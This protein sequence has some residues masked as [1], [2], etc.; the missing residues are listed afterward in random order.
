MILQS[1]YFIMH[2]Y[3]H[4]QTEIRQL[5]MEGERSEEE[6]EKKKREVVME[7]RSR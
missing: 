3:D 2:T 5:E 6:D 4:H 1:S 7:E